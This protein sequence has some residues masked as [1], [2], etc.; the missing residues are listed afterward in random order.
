MA[1]YRN[2]LHQLTDGVLTITVNRPDKLNALTHET[3]FEIGDAF[4]KAVADDA[5]KGIILTGAG[6]KAFI[7]GADIGELATRDFVSGKEKTSEAQKVL[8]AIEATRKP[9]I[10]AVNGYALG[11]GCEFA[12]ACHIRYA[13]SNA[14][15]GLP[16]L[17]LAIMPGFGGTQR[18]PRL[19][20]KGRALEMILTGEPITA[21][22]AYRIGLVNKVLPQGELLGAARETILTI[23]KRGPLA[24]RYAIEAVNRGL[25]GTLAE[26]LAVEAD[27]FGILCGTQDMREG[28]KA[29]LEKRPPAFQGK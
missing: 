2:I 15:L 23:A 25:D 14:K 27:L 20:G 10:A 9:V 8:D 17:K 28:M 1:T 19:V 4:A 16:E 13:S 26:G 5:V 3:I 18:L 11:G 6:E 24:V 7:A 12:L 22:E 29:F 21:D